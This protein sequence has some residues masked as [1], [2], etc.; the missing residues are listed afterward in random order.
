MGNIYNKVE[1]KKREKDITQ[2]C[3]YEKERVEA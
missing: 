1:R 3:E 2:A